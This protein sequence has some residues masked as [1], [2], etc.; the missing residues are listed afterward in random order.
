MFEETSPEIADQITQD[1]FSQASFK[2]RMSDPD[3][4]D[5]VYNAFSGRQDLGVEGAWINVNS[6]NG[7]SG[8]STGCATP[9]SRWPRSSLWPRSC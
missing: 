5:D 9:R 2:V 8:C 4:F 7:S 3:R 1:T 6:S